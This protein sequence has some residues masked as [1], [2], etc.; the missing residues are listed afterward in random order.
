MGLDRDEDLQGARHVV[1]S[2]QRRSLTPAGNRSVIGMSGTPA[3]FARRLQ[4]PCKAVLKEMRGGTC[5]G[6]LGRVST[7]ALPHGACVDAPNNDPCTSQWQMA[8]Y[9]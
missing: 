6:R 1:R 5:R 4:R 8:Q 3:R 7:I 2:P 9:A